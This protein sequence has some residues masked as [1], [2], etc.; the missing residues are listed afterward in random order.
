MM[1]AEEVSN[2]RFLDRYSFNVIE[3]DFIVPGDHK[4]WSSGAIR[5]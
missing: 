3:R 2:R 4:A 5:G 1:T